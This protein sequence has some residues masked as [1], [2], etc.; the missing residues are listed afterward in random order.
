L[1][2]DNRTTAGATSAAAR[3]SEKAQLAAYQVLASRYASTTS[4]QWQVPAFGL[5][6][7][8]ALLAGIVAT[9]SGSVGAILATVSVI[10]AI[11]ALVTTRRVE[12]TAWWDRS[13]L[14]RYEERLLPADLRLHHTLRLHE[15]L[16][17]R[18]FHLGQRPT[19]LKL[20][21]W[22]MRL[23]APSLVLNLALVSLATAAVIVAALGK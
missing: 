18:P 3:Q 5:T 17:R 8:A 12:L 21:L 4:F 23:A 2:D 1:R 10:V 19:S 22:V 14:D 7:Q 13:M 6:A 20:Q 9:D 16:K 15:R 11:A